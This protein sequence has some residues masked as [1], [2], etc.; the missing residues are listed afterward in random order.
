MDSVVNLRHRTVRQCVYAL[1]HLIFGVAN[2][3]AVPVVVGTSLGLDAAGIAA[4]AQRTFFFS[5]CASLIQA[6][7]GHRSPI[8]EG[9]AGIWYST[10]IVMA[11]VAAEVGKPLPELRANLELGL[12][13]AGILSVLLGAFRLMPY[14][15][16]LFTP[17][18]NGTFLILLSLQFSSTLATGL[19]APNGGAAA[20]APDRVAVFSLTLGVTLLLSLKGRGFLQSVAVLVGTAAGWAAAC[21][22]GLQGWSAASGPGGGYFSPPVPFAWGAPSFDPGVTVTAATAGTVVLANLIASVSGM[23]AL[24]GRPDSDAVYGRAVVCTGIADVLAGCGSVVG[25][26][27]YASSIGF[28][29]L[30]GVLSNG[31]FILG[32]AMLMILGVIPA[33]GRFF[34]AM[35]VTVGY[36]VLFAVFAVIVGLGIRDCARTGLGTREM[37]I[38]GSSVMVGNGIAFVP[39]QAFAGVPPALS[40]VLANGLIVGVALCLLLEHVVFRVPSKA[41]GEGPK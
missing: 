5:G 8:F 27:P 39:A 4:F 28:G 10:F 34:A 7:W 13:A 20:L 38:V 6:I 21:L 15:R 16:R 26:V 41:S 18:V 1:Q 36:A 37:L 31:P 17:V 9:P 3:A 35:P 19:L 12:I 25:F 22:W 30:T 40:Y 24:L 33:V 2:C 29:A 23:Q 11:A 32:N 14:V